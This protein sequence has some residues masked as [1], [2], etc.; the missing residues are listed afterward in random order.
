MYRDETPQLVRAP[1]DRDAVQRTPILV[2]IVIDQSDDVQRMAGIVEQ[3]P[4]QPFAGDAGADDQGR[5]PAA[6]A[7]AQRLFLNPAQQRALAAA[8]P[9]E[10]LLPDPPRPQPNAA[11]PGERDSPGAHADDG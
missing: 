6:G 9:A 7:L 10:R 1:E 5:P 2:R 8:G 11:R 4:Q 3:L